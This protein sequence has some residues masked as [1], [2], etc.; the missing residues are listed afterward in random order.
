MDGSQTELI[1]HQWA[2]DWITAD[3]LDGGESPKVCN[4]LRVR[5]NKPETRRFK[6]DRES[7]VKAPRQHHTGQFWLHYELVETDSGGYFTRRKP[8]T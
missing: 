2:N 5:L 3:P 1:V 7:F 4:P 8:G 6:E